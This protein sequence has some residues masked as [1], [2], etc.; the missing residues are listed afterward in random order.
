MS[1][2]KEAQSSEFFKFFYGFLLRY[3]ADRCKLFYGGKGFLHQNR[4][5]FHE[6]RHTFY[7]MASVPR[8]CDK[9]CGDSRRKKRQDNHYG[10]RCHL[11]ADNKTNGN[12]NHYDG[13][14][15]HTDCS[16]HPENL[17]Y[18]VQQV[19]LCLFEQ[20]RLSF[21]RIY[22]SSHALPIRRSGTCIPG[23]SCSRTA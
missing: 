22:R 19:D 11:S 13:Y 23:V 3:A 17:F 15:T 14:Q 6:P 5:V 16:G 20:F 1:L 4:T 9:C 21:Q 10:S 2:L 12:R 18:S 8:E 7:S